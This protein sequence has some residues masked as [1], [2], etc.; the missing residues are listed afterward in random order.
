MAPIAIAGLLTFKFTP[1]SRSLASPVPLLLQSNHPPSEADVERIHQTIADV[2]AKR[3]A[4]ARRSSL[5]LSQVNCPY[6]QFIEAHKAILSPCRRLPTELIVEIFLCCH[7][8]FQNPKR[9]VVP[10]ALSQVCHRW[11][12]IALNMSTLWN[13]LPPMRLGALEKTQLKRQIALISTLLGRSGDS[14][15][16]FYLAKNIS[17]T[18]DDAVVAMLF[19]HSERWMNISLSI[20]EDVCTH[21]SKVKGRLSSLRSLN[22]L[23]TRTGH[24]HVDMFEVAPNLREVT[25]GSLTWPGIIKLP[26]SQLTSFTEDASRTDHI[27]AVFKF[28][29]DSL[30]K[31]NF[32]TDQ[33]W[34]LFDESAVIR[35]TTL[36]NLTCLALQ[37]PFETGLRTLLDSLTVPAL[38]ELVLKIFTRQPLADDAL[39]L[40]NRSECILQKL[41]IH[42]GPS[43]NI[44]PILKATPCLTILDIND[45]SQA[46]ICALT[47]VDTEGM[48]HQ[49]AILPRLASLTIRV[50][51]NFPSLGELN[52]LARVRCDLVLEQGTANIAELQPIKVFNVASPLRAQTMGQY[53]DVWA[54]ARFAQRCYETFGLNACGIGT[55]SE[56]SS[57]KDAKKRLDGALCEISAINK[58]NMISRKEKL[59]KIVKHIEGLLDIL[60]NFDQ[61]PENILYLYL[62][63]IDFTL[64]CLVDTP[65]PLGTKLQFS[66]RIEVLIANWVSVLVS[67]SPP[68]KWGWQSEGFLTYIS[69][70][71]GTARHI[72]RIAFQRYRNTYADGRTGLSR[73]NLPADHDFKKPSPDIWQMDL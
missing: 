72:A 7:S 49:W 68:M 25:L 8:K 37:T 50:G 23:L 55:S 5:S 46:L 4:K 13:D 60:E 32:I 30:R 2:E 41:V 1:R 48:V 19:E 42:T 64:N 69:Q 51:H 53:F 52:R 44:E 12:I 3:R 58:N 66:K 67:M 47:T 26:W 61:A 43:Q 10:W 70:N 34:A 22:L 14:G 27:V 71:N 33:S 73:K 63:R 31:L 18:L 62:K 57:L 21:F 28:A 54:Y 38:Q 9:N 11:R 24:L 65:I 45:P 40:I 36:P 56:P 16:T 39:N 59:L 35:P 20:S 15:L 17:P 6:T 29:A